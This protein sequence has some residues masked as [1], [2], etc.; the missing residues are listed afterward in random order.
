[1]QH[2]TRKSKGAALAGLAL[3]AV[4][5]ALRY[6]HGAGLVASILGLT[7]SILIV[8]SRSLMRDDG[9]DPGKLVYT[10]SEKSRRALWLATSISG[11]ALFF[12]GVVLSA[13]FSFLDGVDGIT[14]IHW[15]AIG[16]ACATGLL[17]D[18]IAGRALLALTHAA[19]RR[20]APNA[21]A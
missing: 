11:A 21:T 17:L 9:I 13:V 5:F 19:M 16:I 14:S 10:K 6:V 12:L 3:L 15:A 8:V 2:P 20:E 4:A 7:A 1:M 18:G